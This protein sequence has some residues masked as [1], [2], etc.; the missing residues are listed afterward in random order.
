[1]GTAAKDFAKIVLTAAVRS[2][3]CTQRNLGNPSP[4]SS[5]DLVY[6]ALVFLYAEVFVR[7]GLTAVISTFILK[8]SRYEI[9]Y[10]MRNAPAQQ[11]SGT[12][13]SLAFPGTTRE[14]IEAFSR[15]QGW[16]T[17]SSVPYHRQ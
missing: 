9:I 13:N 8:T 14:R 1:M 16:I 10:W 6:C 17:A 7:F 4:D 5:E 12:W 3:I 2:T 15:L 11:L